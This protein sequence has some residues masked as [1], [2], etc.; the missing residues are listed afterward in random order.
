MFVVI[1]TTFTL[2]HSLAAAENQQA[3]V[4]LLDKDQPV[5]CV[6]RVHKEAAMDVL[7]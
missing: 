6:G 1:S 5:K 4:C 3:K 7:R 2:A